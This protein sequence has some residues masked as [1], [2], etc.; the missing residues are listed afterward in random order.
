MER[1][2]GSSGLALL[3]RIHDAIT[4]VGFVLAA[5][6]LAVIVCAY[7]YEVSARYFFAAP[8][9]WA[10]SLVS[11][12]LLYMVF[13]AMPELTRL[14]VHIFISIV[15][16]SMSLERATQF[17]RISYVVAAL[18]CLIAAGFCM[19]ATYKQFIG[20]ISTVNEWR[21]PKW[22]LSLAIPYGLFSTSIYYLRL[23]A[24][25]PPYQSAETM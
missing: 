5:V 17:Q 15:L 6:C 11:Y 2:P 9:T 16:D 4:R 20:N 19:D 22:A 21:V 25:A 3:A 7:A 13:L 18:A 23:V 14:R 12:M 10:S 1:G 8:T 24:S